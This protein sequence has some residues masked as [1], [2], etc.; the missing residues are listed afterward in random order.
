[1]TEPNVRLFKE[2]IQIKGGAFHESLKTEYADTLERLSH[3][4]L[5]TFQSLQGEA[6][7][8]KRQIESIE[9]AKA[10]LIKSEKVRPNMQ[11][12]F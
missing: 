8:L 6:K 9:T 7:L 2:L 1:M 5:E 10:S 4:T 11:K 3:A 12:A